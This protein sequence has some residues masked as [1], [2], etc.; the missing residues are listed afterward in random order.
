[1]NLGVSDEYEK[2]L[3]RNAG[4]ERTAAIKNW[5]L[6]HEPDLAY[7]MYPE[8]FPRSLKTKWQGLLEERGQYDRVHSQP[9]HTGQL[10][11]I[12]AQRPIHTRIKLDQDFTIEVDSSIAG[13]VIALD[14]YRAKC[15]PMV[16]R[17]EGTFDPIPITPEPYGFPIR[18][19]DL[20]QIVP[21]RQSEYPGE[22]GHCFLIGPHGLMSYYADRFIAGTEVSL[23]N[24]D[25]MAKRLM[26]LEQSKVA[27]LLENV[28]FE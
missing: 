27:V 15:Y 24:L 9:F 8:H 3:G 20:S 14:R 1:M 18:E 17:A 22:H 5:I 25:E 23:A 10:H 12:S 2:N 11:E 4:P 6:T 28:I 21:M 16:L 7:G 19:G 26:E 13:S